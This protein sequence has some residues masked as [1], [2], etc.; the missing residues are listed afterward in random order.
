MVKHV[1]FSGQSNNTGAGPGGPWGFSSKVMVWNNQSNIETLQ[2]LGSSWIAP[3]LGSWPFLIIGGKDIN[4]QGPHFANYL[5]GLI[6]ED[7]RLVTSGSSGQPIAK[8]HDGVNPGPMYK[9]LRALRDRTGVGSFDVFLWNQGSA[10]NLIS[11]EYR[12][13]WDALI[14]LMTSDGLISAATAIV[15][16]ETGPNTP[17][18]NA[19]LAQIAVDDPRAGYARLG[20]LSTTDGVHWTGKSLQLAGWE[21]VVALSKTTT[22]FQGIIPMPEDLPFVYATG[23][24]AEIFYPAGVYHKVSVAH[25]FG[26]E[27]LIADGR[28][29]SDRAGLWEFHAAG[30]SGG[31]KSRLGLI[32]DGGNLLE[33]L[34]Y[35]GNTDPPGTPRSY[36][37]LLWLTFPQTKKYGW[38]SRRG[39]ERRGRSSRS[40][41]PSIA[42]Y[43]P[44]I[45]GQRECE[46]ATAHRE[47]GLLF[48]RIL[49]LPKT[50]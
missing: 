44:G 30:F 7:V 18:I 39:P 25:R 31:N 29:V 22:Q 42:S 6:D 33:S 13:K 27:N 1:L 8:W 43:L 17:G 50:R 21:A 46:G 14:D 47:N 9:R 36:L 38:D 28:F 40:I 4:N 3:K 16:N 35:T 23:N 37:G 15:V 2:N 11:G 12:A 48:L 49:Y 24:K 10:D 5:S 45:S 20:H 41:H 19:V 34:V 26:A 32:D